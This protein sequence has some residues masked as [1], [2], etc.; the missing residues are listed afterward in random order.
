M[1]NDPALTNVPDIR[2]RYRQETLVAEIDFCGERSCFLGIVR[3]STKDEG[4]M[5]MNVSIIG[6]GRLGL[7]TA[8]VLE[9]TGSF[10]SLLSLTC[11]VGVDAAAWSPHSS[12]LA[13]VFFFIA[14]PVVLT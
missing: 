7:C 5:S 2:L 14:L 1:G 10:L 9:K 4:E 6:V 11:A 8:L 3:D 13:H 12:R